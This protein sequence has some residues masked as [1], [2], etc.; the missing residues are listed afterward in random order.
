MA[1]PEKAG[2]AATEQ[3]PEEPAA[4]SGTSVGTKARRSLSKSRRE[5]TEEELGQSGV[6][7]MLFDEVD[8]LETEVSRLRSYEERFHEADKKVAVL[9]ENKRR[10][11]A[12]EVLYGVCLSLGVGILARSVATPEGLT[13][14]TGVTGGV[15][16]LGAIVTKVLG[17]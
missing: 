7:L 6:R 3:A 1:E 17:R 9:Q 11:I 13:V 8:R 5:L 14:V 12:T 4:G 16:V 15:L 2:P 10:D